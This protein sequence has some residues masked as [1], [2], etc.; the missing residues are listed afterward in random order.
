M[1][2]H[3]EKHKSAVRKGRE[4]RKNSRLVLRLS[5]RNRHSRAVASFTA[6]GKSWIPGSTRAWRGQPRNDKETLLN[7]SAD[8][9]L[10]PVTGA[11][12]RRATR[13]GTDRNGKFCGYR[14]SMISLGE[15]GLLLVRFRV[16]AP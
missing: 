15:F 1:R 8:Q 12:V 4:E 3:P 14:K 11:G 2:R 16:A 9:L 7:F 10:N 5:Y 13:P 6:N